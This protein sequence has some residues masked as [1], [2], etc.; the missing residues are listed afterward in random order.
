MELK[1]QSIKLNFV[2]NI[3]LTVS[4]V[5][6]PLITFRYVA[7]ILHPAGTG[8]VGFA[9][10][11][12]AYFALFAQLG[13]PTYGVR[14]T[15]QVRDNKEELS[16]VVQEL[17]II[18]LLMSALVYVVF[19]ISLVVVPKF[20]ENKALLIVTS[21]TIIFN[22]IG[23]EWLYKGLEQYSYITMRSIAFK[24]IAVILMFLMIKTENDTVMY[25]A[26]TIFAGSASSVLNLLHA[27]KYITM[28]PVGK[29]K[30]GRH[31]KP[32]IIFFAMSCATTIYT[33]LDTVMLGFMKTDT[34][35]GYYNAA[36]KIKTVLLGVVTAL[37][38]VLLPRA[39][40]YVEQKLM[41]EFYRVARKAIHFVFLISL[42]MAV[43]FMFFAKEG[44]FFLSGDAYGGSI[45][46]MQIIM[47]TLVLIGL[48]NIMGIQMLVPLG[49]EK[50][51]LCSEIVG[52]FVDLILNAILIPQMASAGAAIGTLV[53]EVAVFLVQYV[54]LRSS[55]RDMFL[56][57]R[58]GALILATALGSVCAVPVKMLHLGSFFTLCIS[59][60]LFFGVYG[61]VMILMK[62]ELVLEVLNQVLA[63]VKG[64]LNRN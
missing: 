8:I 62:E 27:R 52:A 55:V 22:A 60:I 40:Y 13:I 7:E 33:N 32:I 28:R 23:M 56:D 31:M 36:V 49:G 14:A 20:A 63:M 41:D 42:P 29:Y 11:V 38:T 35:V 30:F 26:I 61:L 43:Y 48:T 9:S 1:K 57:M 3:I 45:I 37:G 18:N 50:V 2:M 10:S 34:D 4:Q 44:I 47:P 17:V 39:S 25:A 54:A 51:V 6:F 53:A 59:A 21:A 46:P 5:I 19:A 64:K 12:V 24:F 15:A 16:R 58:Y